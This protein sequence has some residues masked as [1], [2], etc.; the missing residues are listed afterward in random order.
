MKHY[1]VS[2]EIAGPM[3]I[4]TRP[5][6]GA[7]FVSYPA[8]TY[9]AVRG[10]ADCVARWKSAFI[11]PDR[12]EICSPI[13]FQRYA[14]NYG[15]PLRHPKQVKKAAAYQLFATVLVD[16]CYKIYGHVAEANTSPGEYNH[17]HALQELFNRRLTLGRLYRTPC[18]GWSEFMPSY[19]GPIRDDTT[20][21][22]DVN[23]TVPSMLRRVFNSESGGKFGPTYDQNVQIEKG[24]L[25]FA[26]RTF[27][28]E[29]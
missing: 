4:F 18:L 2:F 6:S 24:V 10:M 28:A 7:S 23:L 26:E 19:F 5:D 29:E 16:V 27:G 25:S 21:V 22:Q 14:T 12:V 13:Q 1:P 20:V 15:G 11:R 9:S 17:L 3:A 8:P